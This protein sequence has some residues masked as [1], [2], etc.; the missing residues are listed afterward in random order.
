MEAAE[1]ARVWQ[2][3]RKRNYDAA[4]RHIERGPLAGQ[5]V[6]EIETGHPLETADFAWLVS[7]AS[8]KGLTLSYGKSTRKAVTLS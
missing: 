6:V 4:C 1:A 2:D 7:L 3:C 5:H 8:D